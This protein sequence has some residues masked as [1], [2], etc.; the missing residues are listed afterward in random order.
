MG[1]KL[2]PDSNRRRRQ[3]LPPT[4]SRP[5]LLKQGKDD[6]FRQF[7]D[8]LVKFAGVLRHIREGLARRVGVTPPQ[9][10][11]LM[12]LARSDTAEIMTN[13][14]AA[15]LD[16]T[17]AFVVTESNKLASRGFIK[18][19]RNPRD[20]RSV[21]ISLTAKGRRKLVASAPLIR[22]VN[23]ILFAPITGDKMSVI[24][25]ATAALLKSSANAVAALDPDD[26]VR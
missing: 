7:V 12:L 2:Q 20:G 21:L 19:R 18:R 24:A 1:E 25:R 15:M 26:P 17:A 14:L 11:L 4:V 22:R 6:D 16:V 10:T 13:R 8:D 23:D 3:R 9:Y 5:T